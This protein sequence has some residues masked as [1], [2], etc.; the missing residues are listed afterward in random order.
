MT[1]L[2]R[3]AVD[4]LLEVSVA[5]SFTN[6]GYRARRA[7]YGWRDAVPGSMRGRTVAVTGPTS[8]LGRAAATSFAALGARL[9]LIG[10]N[11]AKLAGLSADLAA[12]HREDRFVPVLADMASL[13]SV[14]AA[15]QAIRDGEPRLDV[16]V[17]NAGAMFRSRSVSPDGIEA[18]LAVLVVGP[19]ALTHG[20]LPLLSAAPGGGR[21]INV[22]SG[23]MYT[24]A[25]KLDD[26]DYAQERF[27]GPRAYARAKRI[28]VAVMREW[29]RRTADSGVLFSAMHPGWADTPGLAKSLPSFHRLMRPLLRTPAEGADTI[30]WLATAPG[31]PARN[32][33]LFLDRRIRP[34]DRV[35]GTRLSP[36]ER[37]QLWDAVASLARRSAPG[38]RPVGDPPRNP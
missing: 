6:A 29:A 21:V 23:G 12:R 33:R 31:D 18:T 11:E 38:S 16:L 35:P 9:L 3:D 30:L 17:D 37:Q 34:F 10:R 1:A 20:L 15:V 28:G 5:G 7:L 8:G 36:D 14:R 22:T 19:F 24:Q 27:S 26:L 13:E 32:G 2:V 4:T 25:V